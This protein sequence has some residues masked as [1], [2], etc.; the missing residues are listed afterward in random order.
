MGM[1]IEKSLNRIYAGVVAVMMLTLV[2]SSVFAV[3]TIT[4]SSDTVYTMVTNSKGNS[5]TVT[6]ANVQAAIDDLDTVGFGTVWVGGSL[7]M[8]GTPIYP[9]SNMTIDFQGNKVTFASGGEFINFTKY[10]SYAYGVRYATVR[11]AN[12]YPTQGQTCGVITFYIPSG[13]ASVTHT[14]RYNTVEDI[15]IY[16]DSGEKEYYGIY[17]DIR[18]TS[19]ICG[20]VIRNI[21][22]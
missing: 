22:T 2:F 3:R 16:G 1:K 19:S 20:N 4:D 21:K 9:H 11:N 6:R 13:A 10:A 15:T 18:G 17:M 8:D 5:W 14:L 12:V 7:S